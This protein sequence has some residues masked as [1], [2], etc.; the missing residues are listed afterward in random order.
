[1]LSPSICFDIWKVDTAT[2]AA[3]ISSI[4]S[5]SIPLNP[6]FIEIG[7]NIRGTK[8]S[9]FNTIITVCFKY[10]FMWLNE[11]DPPSSISD[12]GVA[13]FAMSLIDFSTN[14]GRVM[15]RVTNKIPTADAMISG[16][17]IIPFRIFLK[18]ISPSL[19]N[20]KEI[21]DKR[22]NNGTMTAISNAVVPIFPSP[23]IEVAIGIPNITK[24]LLNIPWII[25]P[26][27]L[28]SFSIL[29]IRK[30]RI[31]NKITIELTEKIIRLILKELFTS[32]W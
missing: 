13:I 21:T 12:S 31:M 17:V 20:S 28:L 11:N 30:H 27:F 26:R 8:I 10:S 29:G 32:L 14:V 18:F 3:N 25:T 15:L 5:S 1:M 24:L 23:Y 4:V 7:I 6:S 2:G 9:L 16:F 22:L 19:N